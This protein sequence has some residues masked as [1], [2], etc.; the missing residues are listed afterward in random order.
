MSGVLIWRRPIA[1]GTVLRI[2]GSPYCIKWDIV[3]KHM[4]VPM[5]SPKAVNATPITAAI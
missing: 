5:S 4:W 3:L 2:E 1:K